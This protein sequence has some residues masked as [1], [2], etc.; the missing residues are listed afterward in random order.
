MPTKKTNYQKLEKE[1]M[2]KKKS[3]WELWD[4]KE[5]KSAFAFAEDYK[6]FLNAAKTEGEA[7]KAGETMARKSGFKNVLD[8]KNIKAG[9]K[10]YFVQRD[11]SIIFARIGK[12]PL[13]DGVHIVMSHIDSPHLDFKVMPLY[14][15]E[16]IAFLKTHYYGGIKKYQW[17]TI[18]LALHGKVCLENGKEIEIVIGEKDSDPVF[19]ITDLLPHLDRPSRTSE[20]KNRE[21]KGEDLNLVVGSLPVKDEK[22]KEKVKLA[23]LEYLHKE[24]GIKEEDLASA[25]LQAVPSEKARDLGFDRSM[26]SGYGHDDRVCSF[27]ALQSLLD[28]KSPER[29]SLCIWIDR[30]EIGSEGNTG[31]RSTFI[32]IFISDLLKLSGKEKEL[33]EV[34]RLYA[35]S[36]AISADVTAAVDPD[37]KDVHDLRNAAR[38][39]FGLVLEKYDGSGG[40]SDTSEASGKFISELRNIYNKN[41]INFQI[42]GGLGRIDLGGGGT[43]AVHMANRNIEIIDA[44]VPLFNMHAPLEIVSKA[45][46][47][48]SYLG[49]KAFLEK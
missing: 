47:Y 8:V 3:C 39:G 27:S 26:I 5:K 10:V 7:V 44:G 33:S 25:E 36:Y 34:F 11:K 30:E 23:V 43:I 9:D 46:L 49:Y 41:K 4:E 12:K 1:L 2:I 37:Y 24:Y 13:A 15:D 35:K 40:K 32:D 38:L 6:K 28:M 14:E 16:N 17:P 45:D 48:S 20:L 29:T 19:M 21:V 22:V 42:G 18:A 31:A